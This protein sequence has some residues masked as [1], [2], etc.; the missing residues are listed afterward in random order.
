MNAEVP[1]K[2]ESKAINDPEDAVFIWRKWRTLIV[3]DEALAR[4]RLKRL[5]IDTNF[6]QICGEAKN[7]DDAK[8]TKITS[9]NT[10]AEAIK[11]IFGL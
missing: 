8:K 11:N 2:L 1:W 6:F 9:G 5:L 10:Y 3:D 4:E 7:G